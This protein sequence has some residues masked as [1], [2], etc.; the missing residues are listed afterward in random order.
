M[1]KLLED[2]I[3]QGNAH[4]GIYTELGVLYAKYFPRKLMNHFHQYFQNLNKS[5]LMR[6]CER[7]HLW[8]ESRY[9]YVHYDEYDMAISTMIEHSPTAW[10]DDIFNLA[11]LKVANHDWYYKAIDFY[12]KEH[13]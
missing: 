12:L 4:V 1:T 11:I 13:P 8:A 3:A 10:K 7:Y 9:L 5:K 6:V 2:G